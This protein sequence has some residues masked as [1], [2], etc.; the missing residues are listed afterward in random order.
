MIKL[1]VSLG[2]LSSTVWCC[3]D[4]AIAITGKELNWYSLYTALSL[5]VIYFIVAFFI[6]IRK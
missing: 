5:Y 2:V 6:R 1:I 3:I 4:V